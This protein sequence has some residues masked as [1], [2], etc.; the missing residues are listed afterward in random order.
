MSVLV[1]KSWRQ[2]PNQKAKVTN[3]INFLEVKISVYFGIKTLKLD[4]K[5]KGLV[6]FRKKWHA[7]F[8]NSEIQRRGSAWGPMPGF[9]RSW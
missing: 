9:Y 5:G 8:P 4:T 6:Y 2:S 7:W 1:V 3:I